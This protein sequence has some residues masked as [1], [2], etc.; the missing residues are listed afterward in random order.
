MKAHRYG[1]T[2]AFLDDFLQ[3][4]RVG[5]SLDQLIAA[6]GLT[7]NAATKQLRRLEPR[8]VRLPPAQSYF[9]IVAPEHRAQGGPPVEWWLDDYFAWL[10]HPYYLA[11]QTAAAAHGAN[12]QA[13]QATQVMT[14]APRREII[15]GRLRVAFFV[16]RRLARTPRQELANAQAPVQIST[17]AAT[18]F[19]L[20]RYAPRIGGIGRAAETL[21]PLLAQIGGAELGA[22]L[23]AEDEVASAQRLGY[24]IEKAGKPKLADVV[25]RWL[26]ARRP[27]TALVPGNPVTAEGTNRWRIVDN[28]GEFSA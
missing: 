6:T 21:T 9:L 26:P 3:V 11:L 19:D 16:K 23:E 22:V 27:L 7:A 20:V 13:I 17:P 24:V 5:F 25:D 12:P 28:S 4:G 14:D 8:V 2:N 18:A 10:K 1:A 15:L